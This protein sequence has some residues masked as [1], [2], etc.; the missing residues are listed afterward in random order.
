M[1]TCRKTLIVGPPLYENQG[2]RQTS[3]F[4]TATLR[5]VALEWG[6]RNSIALIVRAFPNSL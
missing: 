6:K 3:S 1:E 5:T 4:S 2:L